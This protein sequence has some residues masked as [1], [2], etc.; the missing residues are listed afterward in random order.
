[1]AHFRVMTRLRA[2]AALLGCLAILAGSFTTVAAAT[3]AQPVVDR[4]TVGAKPCSHCDGCESAPC[5]KPTTACLQAFSVGTPVLA[6]ER[7]DLPA[8]GFRM[9]AWSLRTD[10][11][12]GLSPP[13]DPFPPRS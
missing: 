3:A 4:S 12:S 7:V 5:P 11:M 9:V 1:M 13:P 2:L 8:V 10:A 6:A